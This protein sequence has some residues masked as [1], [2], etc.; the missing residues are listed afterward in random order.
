MVLQGT[1][2]SHHHHGTGPQIGH[3]AFDIQELFRPQVRAEPGLCHSIVTQLQRRPG[4]H[5]RVA[6]MGD[7]GKGT[8]VD[9]GRRSLQRLHQIG[10]DRI[11]EQRRH[12]PRRLQVVGGDGLVLI[13]VA[14]HHPSQARFQICYGGGQ[15][16][17]GHDFRGHGN[18]KSILPRHP[19]G[20]SAQ[21]VHNVAQLPV[22]HVHTA[23]PGDLFHINPQGVALLNMVVQHGG[24]QIVGRANGVKVPGKMQ[25]DVLHGHHLSIAAA[26]SPALE[27]E[28]RSQRGLP[29][30]NHGLLAQLPQAVR[31]AHCGCG[32]SLPGGGGGDGGD[33]NQFAIGSFF[34]LKQLVV[35][36]GLIVAILLQISLLHAHFP[37]N[38]PDVSHRT[39]LRNLNV[40]LHGNPLSFPAL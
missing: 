32:L 2:G 38:L 35:N 31:Q 27:S 33:Q 13:G 15:A 40:T 5:D 20:P 30:S 16:E 24:Q 3:A 4:G 18:V 23:F 17:H 29:Q 7:V 6:P 28:H 9:Q 36:F 21:A 14:H 11:L 10:L 37:G 34:L 8:P 1:Y 19:L 25:V 12:G 22:V 26:G 39:S